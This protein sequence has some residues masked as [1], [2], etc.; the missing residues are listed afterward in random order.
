MSLD[1]DLKTTN[2][3]TNKKGG[4]NE[5]VE[6]LYLQRRKLKQILAIPLRGQWDVDR[7]EVGSDWCEKTP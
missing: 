1:A 7:K 6:I 4:R 5:R 3:A 2:T